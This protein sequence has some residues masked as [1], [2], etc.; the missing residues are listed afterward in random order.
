MKNEFLEE[1]WRSRDEFARKHNYDLDAMVAAL[2][3]MERHSLG[4]VVDRSR[5]AAKNEGYRQRPG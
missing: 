1:V 4:E 5:G 3:E 2:K